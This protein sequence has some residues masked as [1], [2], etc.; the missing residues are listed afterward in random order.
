MRATLIAFSVFAGMCGLMAAS[1]GFIGAPVRTIASRHGTAQFGA[2]R[3][4]AARFRA[5]RTWLTPSAQLSPTRRGSQQRAVVAT[6]GGLVTWLL[7]GWFLTVVVIPAA[8]WGLPLLLQNSTAKD[9][10]TRLEAMSDWAQNLSSVLGVG[11]GIEQAITASLNS[12]PAAIRAE[13]AR[14]VARLQARW[15]TTAALRAF[16]DDLDDATGDL[17]AAALILGA[18]RRGNELSS[19][20][21]GMAAA[22]RD[23]V[24]LRRI[25]DAEQSKGRTTA[26]I[27]TVIG[28][29]SLT[30]MLISPLAQPY[31][32]TPGQLILSVLLSCY[33][34]CMIWMRHITLTPRQPRILIDK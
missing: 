28:A 22:V 23:D 33:A 12:A 4:D 7:T 3:F 18:K 5:A 30:L 20:L 26:R 19:V 32:S 24:R 25:V 27:V 17:L 21:D 11:I 9:E 6:V 16:A 13:V 31:H 15:D 8:I 1:L 10:I 2:S 14:L 34:G 29:I